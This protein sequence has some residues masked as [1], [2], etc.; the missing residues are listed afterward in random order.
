M[1][2]CQDDLKELE[3]ALHFLGCRFEI[4]EW[5]KYYQV[6]LLLDLD[7]LKETALYPDL[8][9]Y[10]ETRHQQKAPRAF[11][12]SQIQ[13]LG[14]LRRTLLTQLSARCSCGESWIL[15]NQTCCFDSDLKFEKCEVDGSDS[16]CM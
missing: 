16:S 15:W 11:Y 2:S 3:S 10:S 9:R 1:H 14:F 6:V 8:S 4:C 5:V 7:F 13:L 12:K